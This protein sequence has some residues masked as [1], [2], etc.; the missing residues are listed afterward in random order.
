ML[1]WWNANTPI[2]WN[3]PFVNFHIPLHD[4][5]KMPWLGFEP[6]LL[7]PQ[8][9]GLTTRGSRLD[10]FPCKIQSYWVPKNSNFVNTER[11]FKIRS[12]AESYCWADS[13]E[14]YY[15]TVRY[16]TTISRAVFLTC[17][18]SWW[19]DLSEIYAKLSLSSSMLWSTVSNVGDRSVLISV[20][21][22]LS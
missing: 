17:W 8:R 1:S 15:G 10:K 21:Y 4:R 16:G 12:S 18:T 11:I 5:I 14:L 19:G 20:M 22:P 7:R 6:E 2:L 3:S 9:G 13:K